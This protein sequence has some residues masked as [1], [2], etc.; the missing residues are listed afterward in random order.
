MQIYVPRYAHP[1]APCLVLTL[2]QI[3][4]N[5]SFALAATVPTSFVTASIALGLD[6]GLKYPSPPPPPPK[7]SAASVWASALAS[8]KGGA[9]FEFDLEDGV[10]EG[11]SWYPSENAMRRFASHPGVNGP[12]A[13]LYL[14]T[15]PSST[16]NMSE[17]ERKRI[18]DVDRQKADDRTFRLSANGLAPLS[19]SRRLA[20][21]DPL[22][23]P[24][25][26]STS[27]RVI[28][29]IDL[30]D[31]W[32]NVHP[33]SW[34]TGDMSR[35]AMDRRLGSGWNDPDRAPRLVEVFEGSNSSASTST[36]MGRTGSDESYTS[37]DE[38]M[39]SSYPNIVKGKVPGGRRGSD[40]VLRRGSGSGVGSVLGLG[41]GLRT[42]PPAS[43]RGRATPAHG[44]TS[45]FR[46]P[47]ALPYRRLGS[48]P[49]MHRAR[50]SSPVASSYISGVG[51][52]PNGAAPSRPLS[53][54]N[55]RP[56]LSS[57]PLSALEELVYNGRSHAPAEPVLY[58]MDEPI[59][60]WGGG[61]SVGRN[62]LQL[63]KRA[64]YTNV[65]AIASTERH[66]ELWKI[67]PAGTR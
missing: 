22:S 7:K 16:Q 53:S 29:P 49:Y 65:L 9:E 42:V 11:G 55:P 40:P 32:N 18:L 33:M 27:T 51:P 57:R 20:S 2:F 35:E 26:Y 62:A 10:V 4:D 56:A 67:A 63:L 60:V 64:G 14:P 41:L 48:P 13:H 46:V 66:I 31:T 36:T 3:P 39:S 25:R 50:E 45:P 52:A 28:Q 34:G 44:S 30:G 17:P 61:T 23:A 43:V 47:A 38:A 19:S 15:V 8:L 21:Q 37:V 12:T 58:A 54:G 5:L 1:L 24:P 59:L 6:L